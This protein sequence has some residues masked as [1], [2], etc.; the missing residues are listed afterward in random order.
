MDLLDLLTQTRF[1]GRIFRP[2]QQLLGSLEQLERRQVRSSLLPPRTKGT[3][4]PATDMAT[5]DNPELDTPQAPPN[6]ATN[7]I[8]S[9]PADI[10]R[11]VADY[12]ERADALRLKLVCRGLSQSKLIDEVIFKYPIQ[13]E[14]VREMRMKDW[15]YKSSGRERWEAFCASVNDGNRRFISKLAMGHFS[16]I[17]DFKWISD[18]LPNLTSLDISNI[19]DFVWTPAEIWTWS[20]LLQACPTLFSRLQELEVCN[21]SDFSAHSRVEYNYSYS[22]YQFKSK[23]RLSRRRDMSSVPSTILP[24]CTQLK[25]LGVRGCSRHITWNEWEIHQ[26]VCVFVDALVTH[27]PSTLT[28]LRL[29][30]MSPF[31]SLLVSENAKLRKLCKIELNLCTWMQEHRD[32][33]RSYNYPF[34]THRM[35]PGTQHREEEGDFD[36]GDQGVGHSL[37]NMFKELHTASQE[38]HIKLIPTE[39]LRDVI[40]HPFHFVSIHRPTHRHVEHP[41]YSVDEEMQSALKWMATT[42]GFKPIFAWDSLC[43]DV[44]PDNIDH[45]TT[46]PKADIISGLKAFFE[47]LRQLGIPVRL[48]IGKIGDRMMSCSN[49]GLD[50]SVYFSDYKHHV[51]EGAG[52]KQVLAASQARFNLSN[53]AHLVDELIIQ[54][55]LD[56]PGVAGWGKSN[57]QLSKGELALVARELKGWRKFWARYALRLTALKKLT[58]LIPREIFEAWSLSKQLAQLLGHESWQVLELDVVSRRIEPSVIDSFLLGRY[59]HKR[60]PRMKFLKRAFYRQNE[61][62]LQ[63]NAALMTE[64]MLNEENT[65]AEDGEELADLPKEEVNR[66]WSAGRRPEKR[67]LQYSDMPPTKR[68]RIE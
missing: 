63:L 37:C 61:D 48:T 52:R 20:E 28:T 21:W 50:S 55:S 53:I 57:R 59:L 62:P 17:D 6:N 23:F 66:F 25:T 60:H 10:F 19:K 4:P 34:L 27:G 35:I 44:F 9:I 38:S 15:Y 58:L 2:S 11:C 36:T 18:N 30:D 42:C 32:S 26:R 13:F 31:L 45:A 41:D 43:C 39:S 16:T 7:P 8:L 1:G 22:D 14:D 40:L 56:M 12:L 64:D 65:F 24:A 54:Y 33:F 29:H 67:P 5:D 68:P 51:G 49:S 46:K 3:T 47:T